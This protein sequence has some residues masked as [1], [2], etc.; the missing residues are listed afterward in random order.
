MRW[1]RFHGSWNGCCHAFLS[2]ITLEAWEVAGVNVEQ[3]MPR[4]MRDKSQYLYFV[5]VSRDINE[6]NVHCIISPKCKIIGNFP[7]HAERQT[8]HGLVRLHSCDM[9]EAERRERGKESVKP[10]YHSSC[11][12]TLRSEFLLFT[13]VSVSSKVDFANKQHLYWLTL[14]HL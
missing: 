4:E 7:F 11:K 2:R 6:I 3:A 9:R 12:T 8:A 5:I 13:A 14:P 10:I 1:L